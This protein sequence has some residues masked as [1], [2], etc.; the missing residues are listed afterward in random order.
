MYATYVFKSNN[1][2]KYKKSQILNG[3]CLQHIVDFFLFICS[4]PSLLFPHIHSSHSNEETC[5]SLKAVRF[6]GHILDKINK[7]KT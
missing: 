1:R 2:T 6:I 4:L 3:V 5:K 7:Q